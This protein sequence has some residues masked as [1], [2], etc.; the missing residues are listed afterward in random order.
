MPQGEPPSQPLLHR[1][2]DPAEQ[3][4]LPPC[5]GVALCIRL[6]GHSEMGEDTLRLQSRQGAGST[7]ARHPCLKVIASAQ[8]AQPGHSGVHLD[9]DLQRAAAAHRLGAVLQCLGFAG[10]RLR[11]VVAQQLLHPLRRRVAQNQDGHGDA[12]GPQL[13]GLVQTGHRQIVRPQ[14][15]QHPGHLHR[16]V[17]VS[18]RFHHAH[19]SC[20]CPLP[21]RLIIM[22]Q[23]IQ[24]D[25]RPGALQCGFHV[26]SSSAPQGQI[27][28]LS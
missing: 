7:N 14:L 1:P 26:R 5:I 28:C 22:C 9:V 4:E 6:I 8:E 21:Q 11:D 19:E 27:S 20:A 13:H 10:H 24:I 25:L 23:R 18:I 12:P 16:P 2:D 17:A 3:V 15:L